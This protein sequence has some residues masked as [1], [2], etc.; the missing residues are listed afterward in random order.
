MLL[1]IFYGL[2]AIGSGLNGLVMIVRPERWF[3][4]MIAGVPN[5]GP[6]NEHFV[7]DVGIAFLTC[8]IGLGWAVFH[9]ERAREIHWGVTLFISGHAL[10][11]VVEILRG[12]LPHEHWRLDFAGVFVPGLIFAVLCI[13]SVW[14]RA[15]PA[16]AAANPAG[17]A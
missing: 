9:L 13:P 11:H 3:H 5:T 12:A 4:E 10:L 15:N 14:R 17:P 16:W 6:F 2:M 1:R 8:G 7:M